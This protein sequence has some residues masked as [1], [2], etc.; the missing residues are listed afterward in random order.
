MAQV[1]PAAR[2]GLEISSRLARDHLAPP[3]DARRASS[4]LL[5]AAHD[6][7]RDSVL[8][9]LREL[10]EHLLQTLLL[11]LLIALAAL[12]LHAGSVLLAQVLLLVVACGWAGRA[13]H[14]WPNRA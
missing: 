7:A 2:I 13:Y 4:D 5:G 6:M 10:D 3:R 9:L 12:S 14:T 11:P 8:S 1:G